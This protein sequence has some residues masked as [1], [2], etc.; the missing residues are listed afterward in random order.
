VFASEFVLGT[1]WPESQLGIKNGLTH[2]TPTS[3]LLPDG[4]KASAVAEAE[5]STVVMPKILAKKVGIAL[6]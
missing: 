1:G 2:A 6:L 5:T 3:V 4:L